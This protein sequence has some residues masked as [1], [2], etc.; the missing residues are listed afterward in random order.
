MLPAILNVPQSPADWDKWAYHH[1]LSHDAIRLAI[2]QKFNIDVV[3]QQIDPIFQ[4]DLV[5]WLQRNSQ[6][7]GDMTSICKIQ[8]VDLQDADFK[9]PNQLRSWINLHYEEHYMVETF[10]GVGS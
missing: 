2:R 7:H 5:G 4:S 1:R 6:L 3:D 9:Q 8:G 10:L